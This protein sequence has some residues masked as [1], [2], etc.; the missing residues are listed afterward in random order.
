M[1]ILY[2]EKGEKKSAQFTWNVIAK[3]LYDLIE[4]G[5]YIM[6]EEIAAAYPK[7]TACHARAIFR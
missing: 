3:K 6:Q 2:T 1:E 5:T 7:R 4:S